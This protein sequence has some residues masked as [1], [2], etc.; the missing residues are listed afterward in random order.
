MKYREE[1]MDLFATDESY[2][3]AHCISQDCKM[4]AG[5]AK[6][7]RRRFPK[8]ENRLLE[9]K[10]QVG[11]AVTHYS[12]GRLVFNLITKPKY[13]HKPTYESFEATIKDLKKGMITLNM[14][15]LAIPLLGAGLDKL[16]WA[17][18]REI[19]QTVFADTDIEIMVCKL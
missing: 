8:M 19:I 12:N 16:S 2:A 3:L 11:E 9:Q 4:G 10:P 6:E 5:I 14:D 18:N 7:F 13:W 1:K 15:K 17:K